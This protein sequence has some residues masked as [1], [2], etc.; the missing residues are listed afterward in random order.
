MGRCVQAQF[1]LAARTE[2][3]TI[4]PFSWLPCTRAKR[5]IA[6]EA[7]PQEMATPR[8]GFPC[9]SGSS[10]E[11]LALSATTLPLLAA[12][13]AAGIGAAFAG[14]SAPISGNPPPEVA[15]AIN[16]IEGKAAYAHTIWG[17]HVADLKTGEVL[18]DQA[19]DKTL[20][21]GSIMKVYSTSTVL[22]AYGPDYRF[23]TPVYR[24]G[25]VKHG[26]LAGEPRPRCVGR[27]QLRAA[28]AAGRNARLQQFPRDR[29]QLR[30]HGLSRRRASSRAA[31][32]SPRSTSS[33]ARSRPPASSGFAATSSSTTGCSRPIA[34]GT[35]ARSR[36]SGSTRTS[37][38]S[39]RRPGSV[40]K[41]ATVDWR[42]KIAGAQGR[43]R[44][45]S[46]CHP[47]RTPITIDQPRP[48]V[49]A[50]ARP[51]RGRQSADPQHLA[52][53]ASRRRSRAP[54]LSRRWCAPA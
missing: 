27:F 21:P 17:I 16:D 32:R 41:E 10:Q 18:I 4:E 14:E 2:V 54:P 39:R 29:P 37:S 45:A 51:D 6:A 15:T 12:F 43:L 5:H 24:A 9:V 26:T 3:L 28:R 49:L 38:T 47:I 22:D 11:I 52:G 50:R 40:G 48:G 46:R 13:G 53:P 7:R 35:T 42:P 44:R 8:K 34:A 25:E 36:R 30:R 31:T 23:R 33:P 1:L 19:G 20:V